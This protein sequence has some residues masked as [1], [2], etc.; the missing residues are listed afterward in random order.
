MSD[1]KQM[2]GSEFLRLLQKLARKNGWAY[3]WNPSM[4][5]GSHGVLIV[6]G[7]RTVVRNLADE[8]KTGTYHAMLSQLELKDKDLR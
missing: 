8:L 4:G 6:N 1:N 5:K 7:K 3:Q 2:K